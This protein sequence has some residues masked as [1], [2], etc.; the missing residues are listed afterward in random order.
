MRVLQTTYRKTDAHRIPITSLARELDIDPGLVL[1]LV[2][3]H[4]GLTLLSADYKSIITIDER[5]ALQQKIIELLG[6]GVVSKKT[7]ASQNDVDLN[8]TNV[9]IASTKEDLIDSDDYVH[10]KNYEQT[11]FDDISRSLIQS[12]SDL[13]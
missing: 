2:R 13:Q 4:T 1:Q 10:S 3:S 8:S 12:L 5:D 11:I 7:F 6:S 9:L